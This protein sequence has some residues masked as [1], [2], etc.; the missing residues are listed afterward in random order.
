[1]VTRPRK[2]PLL[3]GN[4]ETIQELWGT[5]KRA[6]QRLIKAIVTSDDGDDDAAA[7]SLWELTLFLLSRS[8]IK[9]RSEETQAGT[10]WCLINVDGAYGLPENF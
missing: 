9:S 10:W 4:A 3:C 6:Q 2:H 7:A 1:M 5:H 8:R